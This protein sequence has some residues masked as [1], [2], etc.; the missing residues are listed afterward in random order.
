MKPPFGRRLIL[1]AVA[2]IGAAAWAATISM[3]H[4]E[5]RSSILDPLETAM[6]NLRMSTLGAIE[7][8]DDVV[9]IAIDD[10]MLATANPLAQGR[11]NLADLID[12]IAAAGA[13]VAAVDI[14]L[15]DKG[16]SS[17]DRALAAALAKLPTVIAAAGSFAHDLTG[18][19]VPV[20]QDALWPQSMFSD[21]SDVGMVNISTDHSG[22]P[23]HVPMVFM[24]SKGPQP[25]FAAQTAALFTGETLDV[26]TG[27]LTLGH[28]IIPLDTGL[29]M[30]LRLA[31]P[32][33]TVTTIPALNLLQGPAAVD[34]SGKA[35]VL[36]V[37]ATALGDRFPTPFDPDLP[38]VEVMA[39]AIS[40]IVGGELLRRDDM[41]R[42]IDVIGAILLA[43]I[44]IVVVLML[45]LAIGIPLAAGALVLWIAAIWLAFGFGIWLSAALPLASAGPLLILAAMLRYTHERRRAARSDRAVTALKKFQSPALADRI[46]ENPEFL[47]VPE[48]RDLVVSF[49]DLTGFTQ[50]SQD[51]GPEETEAFLK[52]F[53]TFLEQTAE[54][55]GGIVLNFMGDGALLMFGMFDQSSNPA[56]KALQAALSIA[57]QTRALGEAEGF[58]HPMGCRI[59]LHWGS[60]ILSR[61][62]S[63]RQQQVTITGDS[64]NLCSR[65]LEIAKAERATIAATSDF[66]ARI[67]EPLPLP[68]DRQVTHP[69]RGRHGEVDLYVWRL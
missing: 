23:R 28:R 21:V 53:H 5:G 54:K 12:A 40:Q 64:V 8:P 13:S 59:G 55:R 57:Q 48:S 52:K 49:V 2:A 33:G 61:M 50:I 29:Q 51:L 15:T 46:A 1:G 30:P 19:G 69:V 25:S 14:L 26:S 6:V 32:T 22:T 35:V 56:D 45:P 68:F 4:R 39:T 60:V 18:Q 66:I 24:T 34:L 58:T 42:H 11:Q 43:M 44:C 38:G 67:S 17:G 63:D 27:A 62:G 20:T 31:G 36:G 65:L 41:I 37:T 47:L 10:A 16:N 9:I 3:P 7:T